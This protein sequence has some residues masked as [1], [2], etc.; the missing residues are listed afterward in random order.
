MASRRDQR[1]LN[2][3]NK[4]KPKIDAS[5]IYARNLPVLQLISAHYL[6]VVK[7]VDFH[8]LKAVFINI[9]NEDDTCSHMFNRNIFISSFAK[10]L[11]DANSLTLY[12]TLKNIEVEYHQCVRII[13]LLNRLVNAE[14]YIPRE[15]ADLILGYIYPQLPTVTEVKIPHQPTNRHLELYVGNLANKRYPDGKRK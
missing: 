4:S 13:T 5:I 10:L 2:K 6:V 1:R 11:P 8:Q 3:P 12:T 9:N 7:T 14:E 15:V